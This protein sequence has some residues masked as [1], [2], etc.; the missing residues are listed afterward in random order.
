MENNKLKINRHIIRFI[1]IVIRM[2]YVS[3]EI[4]LPKIR[5]QIYV[6]REAEKP[7]ETG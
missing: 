4:K 7:S 1:A 3:R 2:S 5:K 6:H